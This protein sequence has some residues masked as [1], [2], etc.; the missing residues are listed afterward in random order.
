MARIELTLQSISRGSGLEYFRRDDRSGTAHHIP[1]L[2]LLTRLFVL[3][4]EF[5]GPEKPDDLPFDW[6]PWVILDTGAPL[7]VFPFRVWQPFR[8]VIHWL[9]QP[10][11]A[12]FGR[13]L[14][15]IGGSFTYRLGRLRFGVFD[16]S[17]DWLPA[18]LSNALFLEDAPTAP[19]QGVLGLRTRLFETRRLRCTH[20]PEEV[21]GQAW[22]LEDN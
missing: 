15:I 13:R 19:Q 14:S 2:R 17:G 20:A 6:L 22:S 1:L 16:P 8:D 18:V 5:P 3:P 9:D 12:P 7:S 4:R 10:P 11:A 21:F